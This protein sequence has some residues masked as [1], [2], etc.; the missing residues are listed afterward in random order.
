MSDILLTY[1]LNISTKIY[2]ISLYTPSS[3]DLPL[4]RS[5][6][7]CQNIDGSLDDFLAALIL[8]IALVSDDHDLDNADCPTSNMVDC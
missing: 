3:H 7:E 5:L 6:L 2:F 8:F 1:H 4:C